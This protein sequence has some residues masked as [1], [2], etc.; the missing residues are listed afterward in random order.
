M[1]WGDAKRIRTAVKRQ[2]ETVEDMQLLA[3]DAARV[4]GISFLHEVTRTWAGVSG[5]STCST[6]PTRLIAFKDVLAERECGGVGT[7]EWTREEYDHRRD[8]IERWTNAYREA[9]RVYALEGFAAVRA[10][11]L[12]AQGL[13]W[14][15]N[16][17]MV[18]SFADQQEARTWG[19]IIDPGINKNPIEIGIPSFYALVDIEVNLALACVD[20]AYMQR[21]ANLLAGADLWC[22]QV[23]PNQCQLREAWRK[24]MVA[25]LRYGLAVSEPTNARRDPRPTAARGLHI[26]GLGAGEV[27]SRRGREPGS[28]GQ[29][30]PK[31]T[32]RVGRRQQRSEELDDGE[33]CVSTP[34]NT[35]RGSVP[36][37]PTGVDARAP[38]STGLPEN[39]GGTTRLRNG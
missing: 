16:G 38:A 12:R 32:T 20:R 6:M 31:P 18:S 11:L 39:Q 21:L 28:F 34:P 10:N 19:R 9:G 30:L 23:A 27:G 29:P 22:D 37:P 33:T 24:D 2:V 1:F 4:R 26:R 7:I 17:L 35:F 3:G 13:E 5:P 25:A 14:N 15:D 8:R 36:A